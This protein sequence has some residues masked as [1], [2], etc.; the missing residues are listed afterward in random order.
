MRYKHLER[1]RWLDTKP[2]QL[3]SHGKD[4]ADNALIDAVEYP[5]RYIDGSPDPDM[6]RYRRALAHGFHRIIISD[7]N[8]NL[9]H[10][11]A[12]Q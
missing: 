2:E 7:V 12:N 11:G 5:G 10:A 6:G 4:S 9:K 1:N 8:P 3:Y